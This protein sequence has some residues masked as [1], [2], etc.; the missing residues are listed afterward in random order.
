M[1]PE[2]GVNERPLN[3]VPK[4]EVDTLRKAG[5]TQESLW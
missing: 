2:P 5:M 1:E 4:K 3:V